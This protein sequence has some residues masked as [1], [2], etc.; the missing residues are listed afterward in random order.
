MMKRLL[1]IILAVTGLGFSASGKTAVKIGSYNLWRSDLG[2][3]DYNWEVRKFRLA[4]SIADCDFDIFGA[5]EVD[6]RIQKELPSLIKDAGGA[7]YKWFIFSPY[8]KDGGIGD[9]AQALLY[10][11]DRFE[12]TETHHFWFSETPDVMSSGWDETKY[13]RGGCC[14]IF[15]DLKTGDR[16]FIMLSH[17]PLAKT[18]NAK[19]A[20]IIVEKAA[21]Y[22][23]E[24][25]PALFVGDLNTTPDTP[26]SERLREYWTDTFLS[27][28]AKRIS[29]PSGTFNGARAGRD[30]NAANRIDYIYFRGNVKPADYTCHDKLY[31]GFYP[32][33]HCPIYANLLIRK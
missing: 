32:S 31:D 18:A 22:N 1:A 33:D 29:G 8:D 10:K 3:G 15:R 16:F 2:K 5:Q 24:N 4:E 9:K 21:E 25:L 11:S 14:A 30:M 28:P 6:L 26:S 20:E 17:M 23:P 19:A 13:K 27:L 7:D 12:I